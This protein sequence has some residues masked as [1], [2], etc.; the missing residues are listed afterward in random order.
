MEDKNE[1]PANTPINEVSSDPNIT[2]GKPTSTPKDLPSTPPLRFYP[3][4]MYYAIAVLFI[5]LVLTI[6]A[7][8]LVRLSKL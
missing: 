6:A 4:K 2:S 8:I 7:G 5:I 1:K 3:T